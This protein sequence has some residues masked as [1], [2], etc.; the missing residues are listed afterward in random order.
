LTLVNISAGLAQEEG[1]WQ[2]TAF[3]KNIFNQHFATK[4]FSSFLL[5]FDSSPSS[6]QGY[7]PYEAQAVFG[8]MIDIKN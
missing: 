8:I 2:V 6:L 7:V 5:E 3:G 1:R 4:S